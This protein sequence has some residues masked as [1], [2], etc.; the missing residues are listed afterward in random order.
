MSLTRRVLELKFA[1]AKVEKSTK[2]VDK[3]ANI[4]MTNKGSF[5]E[6]RTSF[7]MTMMSRMLQEQSAMNWM[8]SEL[9]L[10][11]QTVI[12]SISKFNSEMTRTSLVSSRSMNTRWP[13][14]G[15]PEYEWCRISTRSAHLMFEQG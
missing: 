2:M 1:K 3:G 8:E 9:T 4:E 6:K 10:A 14:E 12:E 7:M 15:Q 13:T 5:N 11:V